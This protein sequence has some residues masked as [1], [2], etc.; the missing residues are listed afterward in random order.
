MPNRLTN[1]TFTQDV[2]VKDTHGV[3]SHS[4]AVIELLDEN[5][6]PKTSLSADE[7]HIHPLSN[8]RI[9]DEEKEDL[10]VK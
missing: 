8:N 3:E 9:S 10:K 7:M 4:L 6:K 5:G 2:F 1:L